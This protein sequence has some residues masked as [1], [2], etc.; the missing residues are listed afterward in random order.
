MQTAT[1]RFFAAARRA[2]SGF[3]LSAA[4][5]VAAS[6]V[7]ALSLA[8][9]FLLAA[10]QA[11]AATTDNVTGWAWSSGLG[12]ISMN[13]TNTTNG[14]ATSNFGVTMNEIPG[15]SAGADISGY[16]W[17]ETLGWICFGMTCGA[18]PTPEGGSPYAQYRLS[19][20]G[21]SD[22]MWGWAKIM[23]QGPNAGW[24][25]LNCDKDVGPDECAASNYYVSLNNATGTFNQGFGP[26][27][28]AW[29][30]NPDGTGL[31][32][33]DFG[34][35]TTAW[36]M[37]NIGKVMRP[38]GIYEPLTTTAAGTH[39][40]N[41]P[42][43]FTNFSAAVGQLVECTILLGDPT[44]LTPP[45]KPP[46]KVMGKEM[47]ST[48]RNVTTTINYTIQSTDILNRSGG[49]SCTQ[50]A[51][52]Q[53]GVHCIQGIC[54]DPLWYIDS[55]RIAG[56]SLGAACV[57]DTTTPCGA[58]KICDEARG[59]CRNVVRSTMT[60]QP[61]YTH[62]NTWTGTTGVTQDQ[63]LALRCYNSSPNEFFR[64]S[65]Q[66][67]FAG[68]ATFSLVMRRGVPVE[69]SCH[70]GIDNDG[71]GQMD[72]NGGGG[73][74]P[75]RYCQGISYL[76]KTPPPLDCKYNSALDGIPDCNANDYE[77]GRLCCTQQPK[78]PGSQFNTVVDGLRCT[79]QDPKDGYFDCDCLSSANADATTGCYA[80][81]YKGTTTVNGVTVKGD[82]CCNSS[83]E[84]EQR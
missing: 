74:P 29:N 47:T 38:E 63:Y 28:Y 56:S 46:Q 84:V 18:G 21:K 22:Q 31:G 11:H 71:N 10:P 67:E 57:D 73:M 66:C 33:I 25:S 76:C 12:W 36:T 34:A 9:G 44:Q 8:V 4:A 5:S 80:P 20:N 17:S 77:G 35:V 60:R 51:D 54:L 30:Q 14:C 27:H 65:G 53:T 68:D 82:L 16:A 43:T 83:S 64:N 13:C 26:N 19:Y 62:G 7:G 40:S 39:L 24:I 3:V 58:G 78:A 50:D 2:L 32:W 41:F 49:T 42:V 52:C 69:T 23:N 55:C 70:D 6:T 1:M 15:G 37:A 81:Y 48:V 72:C 75:D 79:Y 59:R 61:I 45:A